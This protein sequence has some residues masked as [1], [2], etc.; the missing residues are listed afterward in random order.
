MPNKSLF[1]L[2]YQIT[3]RL[4][5]QKSASSND[6][7]LFSNSNLENHSSLISFTKASTESVIGIDDYLK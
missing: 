4:E 1:R 3:E 2:L 5:L 7:S 6:L